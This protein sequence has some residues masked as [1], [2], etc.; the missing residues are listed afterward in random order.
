MVLRL[1]LRVCAKKE[2]SLTDERE[3]MGQKESQNVETL[4]SRLVD[5][6]TEI[7]GECS[8]EQGSSGGD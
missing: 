3:E 8:S 6:A 1:L 5:R 7:S 4:N 2:K